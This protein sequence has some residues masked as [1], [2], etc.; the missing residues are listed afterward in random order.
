MCNY[1]DYTSVSILIYSSPI[2]GLITLPSH[3]P[4]VVVIQSYTTLKPCSSHVSE[5]LLVRGKIFSLGKLFNAAEAKGD[6]HILM[7]I[8]DRDCVAIEVK[9][10]RTCFKNYCS[11]TTQERYL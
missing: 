9:Y 11:G 3:A 1:T 10:H 7:H 5:Y 4:A 8:R 6:E 2:V